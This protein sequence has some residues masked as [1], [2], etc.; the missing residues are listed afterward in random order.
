MNKITQHEKGWGWNGDVCAVFGVA[1]V[2]GAT[3][4]DPAKDRSEKESKA[5]LIAEAFNVAHETGLTPRQL[6]EQRKELLEAATTLIACDF[7]ANGWD[8][9]VDFAAMRL[10]EAVAKATGQET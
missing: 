4:E 9:T 5:E 6:A 2:I 8:D 3:G 1:I 7:G 10:R